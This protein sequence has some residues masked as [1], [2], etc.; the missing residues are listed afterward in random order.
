MLQQLYPKKENI[1]YRNYNSPFKFKT[2]NLLS[3][4][5]VIKIPSFN[6]LT[7]CSTNNISSSLSGQIF[8]KKNKKFINKINKFNSYNTIESSYKIINNIN[9]GRNSSEIKSI[10]F[11]NKSKEFCLK[12]KSSSFIINSNT[13]RIKPSWN[14]YNKSSN[15]AIIKENNPKIC[16]FNFGVLSL[17]QNKEKFDI[18]KSS[19]ENY[20]PIKIDNSLY[21]NN[22]GDDIKSIFNKNNI[23]VMNNILSKVG[24]RKVFEKFKYKKIVIESLSEED[25]KKNQKKK[26]LKKINNIKKKNNDKFLNFLLKNNK[27]DKIKNTD[28]LKKNQIITA[29][30]Q[31][32]KELHKKLKKKIIIEIK[33]DNIYKI[34]KKFKNF[35]NKKIYY[36]FKKELNISDNKIINSFSKIEV[37]VN[38]NG[39]MNKHLSITYKSNEVFL[40]YLKKHKIRKSNSLIIDNNLIEMKLFHINLE[41]E[42]NLNQ[43]IL[44]SNSYKKSNDKKINKLVDFNKINEI[45]TKKLSKMMNDK[46]WEKYSILKNVSFFV[47]NKNKNINNKFLFPQ[48][49]YGI[50][51][52]KSESLIKPYIKKDKFEKLKS[53]I[54]Y[55]EENQFEYKCNKLIKIYDINTSDNYGNTLLAYSCING[56][57][58]IAQYLLNNGANPNFINI[59]GD[60][61]LYLSLSNNYYNIANLLIQNGAFEH[62]YR[63]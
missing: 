28:L 34:I 55:N 48:N 13:N 17:I 22:G 21:K 32:I 58:K 18:E 59:N 41:R 20:S 62:T 47:N 29:K 9:K 39:Y 5:K 43:N 11:R 44:K 35:Y 52:R 54:Y 40:N 38:T 36:E 10:F 56:A 27:N 49:I 45:N 61:P 15:N 7:K 2:I 19:K 37:S 12:K 23:E 6:S 46:F 42:F 33:A 31:C 57:F 3:L 16:P 4:N 60:T 30:G 14:K 8:T 50:F 24:N 63:K 26:N 1:T 53:L 25:L 51:N